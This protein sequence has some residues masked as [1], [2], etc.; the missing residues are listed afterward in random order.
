MVVMSFGNKMTA[1][2][3][4]V[5]TLKEYANLKYS[6]INSS[7]IKETQELETELQAFGYL[8]VASKVI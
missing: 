6:E 2:I 4:R 7:S 8:T 5:L 1:K 3:S